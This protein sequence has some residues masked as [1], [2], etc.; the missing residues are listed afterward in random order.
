MR[1]L[2]S[3]AAGVALVLS[4]PLAMA[5][6]QCEEGGASLDQARLG[7]EMADATRAA[8]GGIDDEVV[9]IARFGQ[10]LSKYRLTYS[11][12][13]FAVR[14]HPAG[15]W[16]VVHKLN[17]CGTATA[18][19]FDEGLINFFTDSPVRYQ[20]GVWRLAPD[21]QARLK[22]ALLG[23]K[24]G[25]YHEPMYSMVAY[26][27]GTRY[28]NSN[29]WVLELLAYA[30]APEDEAN[31]RVT[32]QSWLR[33]HGYQPTELALGA[34]TRLGAR[35]AKANV[36]FDDHPPELRWSGRIQTVTVD[37][38]VTWLR[39]LPNGCQA[40]GCPEMRVELPGATP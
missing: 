40:M 38:I 21:V 12:A 39:T 33:N 3:A 1:S 14:A 34:M 31:T 7:M 32:A 19:V 15:A 25:D 27:F 11:H 24:A 17:S 26:P 30:V 13:A 18:A 37:S 20:A 29:G 2:R 10:D 9:L 35:V 6:A 8:L 16:S 4:A 28:Q 36:A 5:G 23:K 22:K